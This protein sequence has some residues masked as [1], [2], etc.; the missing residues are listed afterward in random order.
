MSKLNSSELLKA[1]KKIKP[2]KRT[3][4]VGTGTKEGKNTGTVDTPGLCFGGLALINR[5]NF[6]P[7]A[8]DYS[9]VHLDSGRS[10]T[11]V[12][13][14]SEAKQCMAAALNLPIDWT[15]DADTL[16]TDT[17][18]AHLDT[19]IALADETY[20]LSYQLSQGETVGQI[21]EIWVALAYAGKAL[22]WV[23]DR[24]KKA[25]NAR[26]NTK[27]ICKTLPPPILKKPLEVVLDSGGVYTFEP[28]PRGV[29]VA[30]V[31]SKKFKNLKGTF[32]DNEEVLPRL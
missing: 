16:T 30:Q 22:E 25:R 26:R 15:V 17:N 14:F 5:A 28:T 4:S 13:G 32:T 23:R 6:I 24:I 29:W 27:N 21:L 12:L 2:E 7:D 19:V 9:V 1:V 20:Q 3:V 11:S 8:L 10:V 31:S 18:R